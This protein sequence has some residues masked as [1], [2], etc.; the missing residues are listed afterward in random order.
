MVQEGAVNRKSD[1]LSTVIDK[2][3]FGWGQITQIFLSGGM[4][5]GDGA[6]I[7]ILSCII[8][9]MSKDF[10]LTS[11][12][13]SVIVS[14]VLFG[15]LVGNFFA[16]K[17]GDHYGRRGPI[18][19]SML[20]FA[21]GNL[22][23]LSANS[24]TTLIVI[25]FFLGFSIGFGQPPQVALA[26]EISPANRREEAICGTQV[27][28]ACGELYSAFLVWQQDP[29]MMTLNWRQLVLLMSLPSVI[30]FCA[31]FFFLRESPRILA[32]QGRE[33]EAQAMLAE[34]RKYNNKPH[35]SIAFQS[36]QD[37]RQNNMM[38][39]WWSTMNIIFSSRLLGTTIT[40]CFSCFSINLFYYGTFYALPLM[41]PG[42]QLH[43]KAATSL[44]LNAVCEMLGYVCAWVIGKYCSRRLAA[45]MFTL[46]Q[47]VSLIGF[48][49]AT[50]QLADHA[51]DHN[52]ESMYQWIFQLSMNG[53]KLFTSAVFVTCFMLY[54]EL[55][56]TVARSTGFGTA[57][58]CGRMG[59]VTAPLLFE[60]VQQRISRGAFFYIMMIAFVCNLFLFATLNETKDMK[61][62]DVFE[63]DHA[64]EQ[65]PILPVKV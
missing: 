53:M 29:S 27:I 26:T 13:Q 51:K 36:I 3:G 25:Q 40:C 44:M 19:F 62:K 64:A 34:M 16:G 14:T 11:Y 57:I 54:S 59:A 20:G 6:I 33:Q 35:V 52:S 23:T 17:F 4:W 63:D 32:L 5:M 12:D 48:V 49:W 31:C 37:Q 41:L 55:F 50:T 2:L 10:P 56:P 42:M 47:L 39:R 18:L 61:L 58:S 15:L 30:M 9:A 45:L 7:M 65:K 60:F 1:D 8:K 24:F 46:C 21:A 43:I 28:F 38:G 22:L